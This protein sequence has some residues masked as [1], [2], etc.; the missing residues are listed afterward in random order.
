MDNDGC[1]VAVVLYVVQVGL[2]LVVDNT[3]SF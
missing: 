1:T 3:E 2:P